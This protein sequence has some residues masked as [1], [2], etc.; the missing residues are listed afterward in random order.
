MAISKQPHGDEYVAELISTEDVDIEPQK[1]YGPGP[2]ASAFVRILN[3]KRY[4]SRAMAW[5]GFYDTTDHQFGNYWMQEYLWQ[6]KNGNWL[7]S[8]H[9]GSGTPWWDHSDS[10]SWGL[11]FIPLTAEQAL[12]Y[13]E[14]RGLTDDIEE[15]FAED[16]EDA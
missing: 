11:G 4:A 3:G 5:V 9:G 6:T 15:H 2:E 10:E 13:L 12:R 8:G 1:Q 7:L 14:M 16:V